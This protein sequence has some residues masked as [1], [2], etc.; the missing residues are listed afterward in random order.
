[1]KDINADELQRIERSL[2]L[3][4]TNTI[5]GTP[6]KIEV[7]AIAAQRIKANKNRQRYFIVVWITK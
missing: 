6:G 3:L 2:L 5:T 4:F 7:S 1:M